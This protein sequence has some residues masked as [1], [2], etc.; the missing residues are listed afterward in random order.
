MLERPGVNDNLLNDADG[1]LSAIAC[2]A[3]LITNDGID[4]SVSKSCMTTKEL[5]LPALK[6]Y[7]ENQL[8]RAVDKTD[9]D[10]LTGM[11]G[12][13]LMSCFVH[14]TE[15]SDDLSVLFESDFQRLGPKAAEIMKENGV[16]RVMIGR[17]A[18]NT[19]LELKL[20]KAVEKPMDPAKDGCKK[21]VVE[22]DFNLGMRKQKNGA[23]VMNNIEGMKA[24]AEVFGK[25][26]TLTVDNV[27]LSKTSDGRTKIESESYLGAFQIA[28]VRFASGE[29]YDKANIMHERL[30][31][32]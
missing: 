8:N 14:L 25:E 17:D 13:S 19:L 9:L 2:I 5:G 1:S 3:G 16:E 32:F 21:I 22:P 23:I 28:R 26:V 29:I 11:P 18:D 20:K 27:R 24:I 30:Q 15:S 10:D 4:S 12:D 31:K 7:D 6:F